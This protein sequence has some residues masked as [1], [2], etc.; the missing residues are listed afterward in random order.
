MKKCIK[1]HVN[2][3]LDCYHVSRSNR[4]GRKHECKECK[5]KKNRKLP[6]DEIVAYDFYE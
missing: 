3:P 5:S 4:D 6:I 2:K 1:C